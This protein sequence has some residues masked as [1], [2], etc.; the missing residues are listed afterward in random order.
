MNPSTT[1]TTTWIENDYLLCCQSYWHQTRRHT[2]V[3]RIR[4]LVAFP[5]HQHDNQ[6]NSSFMNKKYFILIE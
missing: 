5:I 2:M 6:M 1:M 4:R 3:V